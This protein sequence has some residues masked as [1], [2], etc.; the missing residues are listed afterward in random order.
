[1]STHAM[2]KSY[3]IPRTLPGYIE[4]ETDTF[5]HIEKATVA[6][7]RAAKQIEREGRRRR[8]I[9]RMI[10]FADE[11]SIPDDTPLLPRIQAMASG[12]V[13]A[14]NPGAGPLGKK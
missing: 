7:W 2:T 12:N 3:R 10:R 6:E 5:R 4:V 9:N 8:A 14:I 1:M 11:L 13:V